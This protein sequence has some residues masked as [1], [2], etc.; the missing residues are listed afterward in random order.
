MPSGAALLVFFVLAHSGAA[1]ETRVPKFLTFWERFGFAWAIS[2]PLGSKL[3][4]KQ[5]EENSDNIFGT[6]RAV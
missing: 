6:V 3:L 2:T 4:N 1:R 5:R